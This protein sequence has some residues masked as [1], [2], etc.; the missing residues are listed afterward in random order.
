M[1]NINLLPWR[2]ERRRERIHQ[3]LVTLGLASGFTLGIIVLAHW[4][5][6]Q[7]IEYQ[8]LRNRF[9][10]NQISTLDQKIAEIRELEKEKQ[11]LLDRIKAIE[12]LQTSRPV[13]VHLF[14]ELVTTLP[15]GVFL[16]DLTQQ[17]DAISIKGVAQ[18]NA[19]VSSFMRNIEA[20]PWLKEPQL[21]VVE[22]TSKDGRRLSNFTLKVRQVIQTSREED[23]RGAG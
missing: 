2:E 7:S 20:S 9:L 13:I 10:E 12:M 22:T 17:G 8:Q 18:S 1:A 6:G 11:R 15:E 14:D 4:F 16:T 23:K 5:L 3:F 21:D 19:R